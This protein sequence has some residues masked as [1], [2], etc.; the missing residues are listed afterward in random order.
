[1]HTK[2]AVTIRE[3]SAKSEHEGDSAPVR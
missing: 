1:M 3:K 2:S